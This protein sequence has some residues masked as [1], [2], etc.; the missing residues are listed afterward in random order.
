MLLFITK[1]CTNF[2]TFVLC[3]SLLIPFLSH[4]VPALYSTIRPGASRFC[5]WYFYCALVL[6]YD[7]LPPIFLPW[8]ITLVIKYYIFFPFPSSHFAQV[9]ILLCLA[10][11][12]SISLQA[13]PTNTL[14]SITNTGTTLLADTTLLKLFTTHTLPYIN[15]VMG[16]QVFFW[17]PE[18]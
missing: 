4:L 7:F 11:T 2:S 14:F 12:R 16:L 5:R 3:F 18:P 9:S 17:I 13:A 8:I 10:L 15:P 6:C 1:C